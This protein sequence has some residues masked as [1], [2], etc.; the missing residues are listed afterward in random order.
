[1]VPAGALAALLAGVLFAGVLLAGCRGETEQAPM[2]E[3]PSRGPNEGM[4]GIRLRNFQVGDTEWVLEADTASV[5]REK[6]TVVAERVKVDFFDGPRHVSTLNADQGVLHQATDDLE[7]RGQVRVVTDEGA[8]LTTEVLFWDH[9]RAKIYTEEYVEIT[10]GT[11]TLAG[12]GL[13]ADPGLDRVEIR[14]EVRGTLR[15]APDSLLPGPGG[16]AP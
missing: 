15:S 14:R 2:P 3:E 16:S 1:M 7:A 10:Q 5:F 8:V 13:D 12:Y 6:K 4:R 11:D 9:Q